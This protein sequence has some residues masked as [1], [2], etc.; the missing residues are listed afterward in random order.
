M[1]AGEHLG[2]ERE[3]ARRCVGRA[4]R[5]GGAQRKAIDIGG[6]TLLGDLLTLFA[7]LI[8]ASTTILSYKPYHRNPTP[9][10]TF[11]G[12]LWGAIFQ[13][14]FA[15][16]DVM[17]LD[18]AVFTPSIVLAICYSGV[19]SIGIGYIIWNHGVK[20]LG[21]GRPAIYTYLEPVIASIAAVVFLNE[22]LTVWLVAGAG[23]VLFGVVLVQSG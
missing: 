1:S 6:K 22:P 20:T 16:P 9:A 8:W 11:W 10:I 5:V 18:W 4:R 21:T 17:R 3:T 13:F 7:S 14:L 12:V 23:L 2:V 19:V 15:V